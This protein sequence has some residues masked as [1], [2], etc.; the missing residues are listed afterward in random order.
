MY[1]YVCKLCHS[2]GREGRI[3]VTQLITRSP[4]SPPRASEAPDL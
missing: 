1:M 4:K 2:M 3:H